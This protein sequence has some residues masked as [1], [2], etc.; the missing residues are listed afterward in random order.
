MKV[1]ILAGG[2]GT[3][4]AEET[5]A[6]PKPMVEVGGRPLLWH[7]MKH[8]ATFRVTE[9]VIAL[10]Y[11]A[12]VIK[13]F[14]A[15]YN[16]LS[17]DFTIQLKN[18]RVDIRRPHQDDWTVHLIDT[19]ERT[20]TGGR[21][22]RLEPLLSDGPFMLTYG[23]GLSNVPIDD[24]LSFHRSQGLL[25][26]VTAIR[27]PSRFGGIAF[28]GDRVAAFSEKPEQGERWINGGFMVM[29]PKVLSYLRGDADVLETDLLEHL[30]RDGQLAAF[31]H[32]GFWQCCDTMRDKQH[33]DQLWNSGKA[34]WV[35]W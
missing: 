21:L 30:A 9:F 25:A 34:D 23:D 20:L 4:L 16:F 6:I 33:L 12:D 24:L 10:G 2:H 22:K 1:V 32:R 28:E 11:K 5:V 27:P 8:F 3:R 14:F 17:S 26:T 15:E 29:E 19:G 18:G 7:I 31:K 13:R 35:T